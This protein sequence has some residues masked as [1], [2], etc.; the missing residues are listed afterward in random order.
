MNLSMLVFSYG[1]VSML[2]VYLAYL[3]YQ[4]GN[5]NI[6][7]LLCVTIILQLVYLM[8]RS[9][10]TLPLDAAQNIVWSILILVTELFGLVQSVYALILFWTPFEEK[11]KMKRSSPLPSVDIFIATYNE[12]LSVIT[13][14]IVGAKNVLYPSG[15]LNVYVCDDGKRKD[16]EELCADLNV[17]YIT[18]ENNLHA[19]AGNLNNAMAVTTGEIIVTQDADMVLKRNFL[20]ETMDHFNDPT[21]AFVQTPQTFYNLDIFQKNLKLGRRYANDQDLFMRVLQPARDTQDAM[22]YI[23]SNALFRRSAL[24]SIGGF[25]SGVIT[26]DMATGLLLQ[27]KG[28]KS[29]FVNKQLASGL[30]A[31]T[32][33][34]Y[35]KQ[36]NRWG[37]GTIQVLKKYGIYNKEKLS[38]KQRF[39]YGYG[40]IYWLS[41]FSKLVYLLLPIIVIFGGVQFIKI[42]P[43]VFLSF[44]LPS[45]FSQYLTFRITTQGHTSLIVSQVMEYLVAPKLFFAFLRELFIPRRA[46]ARFRVT[47]K[48]V[49]LNK[50]SFD[51]SAAW[52]H[53]VLLLFHFIALYVYLVQGITG[54]YGIYWLVYNMIILS[55]VIYTCFE[56]TRFDEIQFFDGRITIESMAGIKK[57]HARFDSNACQ[58]YFETNAKITEG[59]PYILSI[60]D[61]K[62]PI[63]NLEIVEEVEN[64]TTARVNF[65]SIDDYARFLNDFFAL[66]FGHS[67][68][69]SYAAENYGN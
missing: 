7:F 68:A 25:A 27:N 31:E 69:P 21:V 19:K 26:E 63:M 3:M 54:N 16:V 22:M 51:L 33:D 61:F 12:P 40:V 42:H 47:K 60:G 34:D 23:G 64:Q 15:K 10:F 67:Y 36:K 30:S 11:E 29:A 45:L 1:L 9:F 44:W 55:L 50:R 2:L 48:G 41:T 59:K 35:I 6:R 66:D 5:R 49:T 65:K 18:R 24:D 52:P 17:H 13:P 8:Y 57:E 28:W 58:L 20:T 14:T 53:I 39:I 62:H 46:S 37:R 4:N 56:R 38:I 32:V 43:L